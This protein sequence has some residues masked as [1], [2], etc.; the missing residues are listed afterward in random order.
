MYLF[1]NNLR[2]NLIILGFKQGQKYFWLNFFDSQNQNEKILLGLDEFLKKHKK[3]IKSLKGIVVVNGPGSFASIRVAL[4]ISNTLASILKIPIIGINMT[5]KSGDRD[6][7][8]NGLKKLLKSKN[9]R[10][11]M[12]LYGKKPNISKPK[13]IF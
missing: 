9:L 1:I 5:L 12:P 6:L 7:F 3:T 2:P 4:S 8:K 13:R 11:I 10:L